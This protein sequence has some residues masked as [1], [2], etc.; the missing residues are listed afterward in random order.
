MTVVAAKTWTVGEV[1]TAANMN[2][3]LRDNLANLQAAKLDYCFDSYEGDGGISQAITGVGFTPLYVRI[4]T[5]VADGSG[6]AIYETFTALV[7]DDPDGLACLIS[8][9]TVSAQDHAIIAIGADGF[10]VDDA[11]ADGHPNKIGITY[12]FMCLGVDG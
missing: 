9:A 11:G 8:T 3:Y 7:D 2:T 4:W 12:Y 6:I 1:V 10:T 5:A